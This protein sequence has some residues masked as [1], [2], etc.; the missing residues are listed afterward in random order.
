MA[1]G[2]PGVL[3][4]VASNAARSSRCSSSAGRR[5]EAAVP[6]RSLGLGF[7][8]FSSLPSGRARHR[9][10]TACRMAGTAERPGQEAPSRSQSSRC[11]WGCRRAPAR[12]RRWPEWGRGPRGVDDRP[13]APGDGRVDAEIAGQVEDRH[14]ERSRAAARPSGRR[15]EPEA[16]GQDRDREPQRAGPG[17]SGRGRRAAVVSVLGDHGGRAP[18]TDRGEARREPAAAA[19]PAP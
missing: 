1:E 11:G 17:R 18:Q 19:P 6:R 9:R 2:S 8:R 13:R 14:R 15:R 12:R 4:R 5:R 3:S 10:T 16:V 7:H